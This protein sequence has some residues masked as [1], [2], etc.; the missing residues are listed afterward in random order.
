MLVL[1]EADEMFNMGFR[2]DMETI[3]K[4]IPEDRQT[5]L[6]TAA[7]PKGILEI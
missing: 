7:M 3:I 4:D 1:D 5:T 2:E 6:F